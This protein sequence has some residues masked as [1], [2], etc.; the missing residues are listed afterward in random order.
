M[1]RNKNV[2][3]ASGGERTLHCR[4]DEIGGTTLRLLEAV[5]DLYAACMGELGSQRTNGKAVCYTTL[6]GER[7]TARLG[8]Q[9]RVDRHLCKLCIVEVRQ[10]VG[11]ISS[12]VSDNDALGLWVLRYEICMASRSRHE[13]LR[14]GT[15][16]TYKK[17]S[18][19]D[20]H[21]QSG[22]APRIG[23]YMGHHRSNW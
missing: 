21:R 6:W 5:V 20:H 15:H 19:P 14:L 3:V 13:H 18:R 22:L 2:R 12:F 4:E 23:Q 11:R 10:Q 16:G 9:S 17:V 8:E 1:A 7:R